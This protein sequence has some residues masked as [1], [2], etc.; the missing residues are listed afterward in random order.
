MREEPRLRGLPTFGLAMAGLVLG[1][2]LAYLIAV[3]DPHHRA[4]VLQRTGH[5]YLPAMAEAALVRGA[6][7]DGGRGDPSVRARTAGWFRA[8]LAAGRSARARAGAGVRSA[9]GRGAD[10]RGSAAPT[11]GERPHPGDRHG[12][13]GRG[14]ARRRGV[15]PLAR[16]HLHQLAETVLPASPFLEP[17]PCWR[18]RAHR[19]VPA[20]VRSARSSTSE[21]RPPPESPL[22]VPPRGRPVTPGHVWR[23]VH[24]ETIDACDVRRGARRAPM[25][26]GAA[27]ALAHEGRKL[28]DLEMEVGWGTEPAYSGEVNSVQILWST[29]GSPSWIWATRWTS[30]SRSG[31]RRRP[32]RWNPSSRRGSSERPATTARG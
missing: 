17:E 25:L 13:A 15:P 7:R 3:P 19:G 2:V 20:P 6:R 9:G 31:T 30:R 27:P 14:R 24:A 16:A 1:H 11:P 26:L 22:A 4:F 23:F 29:T 32:S 5:E 8:L 28:G 10:R 21:P 18:W 12:G